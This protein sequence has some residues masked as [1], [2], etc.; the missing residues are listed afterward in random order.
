MMC[1]KTVQR[2]GRVTHRQAD[3][4]ALFGSLHDIGL[5]A[6]ERKPSALRAFRDHRLQRGSAHL[7]SLLDHII[8]PFNGRKS[9]S[10]PA[11]WF[12]LAKL[13]IADNCDVFFVNGRNRSGVFALLTIKNTQAFPCLTAQHTA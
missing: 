3:A 9:H 7:D 4:F 1:K 10:H 13:L 12:S 11:R 2:N 8:D 6:L 5:H